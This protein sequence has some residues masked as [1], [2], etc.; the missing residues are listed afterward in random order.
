MRLQR[1]NKRTRLW[2][3]D[4]PMVREEVEKD[5]RSGDEEPDEPRL[6]AWLI[7]LFVPASEV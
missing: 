4:R 1:E 2:H 6:P 3:E 7:R 5:E